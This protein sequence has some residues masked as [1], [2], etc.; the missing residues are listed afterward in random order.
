M[1]VPSPE[2]VTT[3][4]GLA[5]E[6]RLLK[7]HVGDPSVR[8]LSGTAAR[9]GLVLPHSTAQDALGGK[10][11][12]PRL[13]TVIALVTALGVADAGPW[14]DAWRR[15]AQHH[16]GLAGRDPEAPPAPVPRAAPAGRGRRIAVVN[17]AR[18]ADLVEALPL[19]DAVAQL[20]EMSEEAAARR[21]DLVRPPRA[22]EVLAEMDDSRAARILGGM[23]PDLAAA[24]VAVMRP[25]AAARLFDG[26][27]AQHRDKLTRWLTT[28]QAAAI[29][30]EG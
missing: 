24:A 17:A 1:Q 18:G 4:E 11:G 28:D 19:D 16:R 7:V 10:R 3:V 22:A 5:Y 15:A 30:A 13:D 21:L 12:L 29:R 26:M 14:R 25:S 8:E 6:L 27:P 2:S 23:R 20:A 9:A